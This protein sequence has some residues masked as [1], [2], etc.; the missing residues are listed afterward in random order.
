[1]EIT[2]KDI[3]KFLPLGDAFKNKL[4]AE[5]DNLDP[6]K[7]FS[8]ERMLWN[9]YDAFFEM[10]IQEKFTLGLERAKKNQIPLDKNFYHTMEQEAKKEME[11]G[12]FKETTDADLDAVR[13]KLE[14]LMK[15]N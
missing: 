3:I 12:L 14:A 10:K 8:I 13:T 1:M 7:K 6:D 2:T 5:F 15:T 9:I 11:A 4:L